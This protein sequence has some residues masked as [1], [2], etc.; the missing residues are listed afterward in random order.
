MAAP[1]DEDLHGIIFG[2]RSAG[3]QPG[4]EVLMEQYKLF[5]ETSE[6]LV[7]RRQVVNTSF[8]RRTP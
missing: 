2:G 4:V 5:A 6:R 3:D 8:S 7:A 1:S